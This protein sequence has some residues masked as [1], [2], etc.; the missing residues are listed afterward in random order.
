MSKHLCD[1]AVIVG[2]LSSL[3]RCVIESLDNVFTLIELLSNVFMLSFR[4]TGSDGGATES[5]TS[6]RKK[7]FRQELL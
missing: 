6:T 7:L 2:L 5:A 4:L 1:K 3:V